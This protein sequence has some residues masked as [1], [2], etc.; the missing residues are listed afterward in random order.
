MT[1]V[2][3]EIGINHNG[4]INLA[5]K[6]IDVASIAG[7]DYVKF[8]KRTPELCVPEDQKS[9]MRETPWGKITY[10][11]YKE[12][13]EFGKKEY[14]EI[15]KYCEE[16]KIQWFASVWDTESIDFMKNYVDVTKVPSAL[17]TNNELLERARKS[18]N[19][20]MLSTGMSTEEEIDKAVEIADPDLIFHTNSTYPCPVNE[21]NMNYIKWLKAKYPNKHI[22]YSGHEYGLITTFAAVA[23]GAEFIERHITL[24]RT[25]WGS[26]QMASVEPIGLIKLTK[27]IRDIEASLGE[28]SARVLLESEKKKKKTL[29]G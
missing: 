20:L 14:D 23:M 13:I 26:D 22:G 28:F 6:L 10:L 8:Q 25:M 11:E 12:K 18:A 9:K 1:H 16:K 24:D 4:D 29:R 15:A 7:C 2:I 5:K 27:G 17:I 21:L 19:Y 3:A